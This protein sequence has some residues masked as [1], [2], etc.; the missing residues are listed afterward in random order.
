MIGFRASVDLPDAERG[1]TARIMATCKDCGARLEWTGV[2][3]E[4]S[5][6]RPLCGSHRDGVARAAGRAGGGEGG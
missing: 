4:P 1:H 5:D 6:S 2:S 3:Q